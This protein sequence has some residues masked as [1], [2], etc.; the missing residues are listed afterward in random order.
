MLR[1]K[2][3]WDFY[4]CVKFFCEVLCGFMCEFLC[5]VSVWVFVRYCVS[6]CVG[7][8]VGFC[9]SFCVGFC[10]NF[11]EEFYKSVRF[12]RSTKSLMMFGGEIYTYKLVSFLATLKY[13][14]NE[15]HDCKYP[16]HKYILLNLHCEYLLDIQYTVPKL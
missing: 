14:E 6:F 3:K 12:M 8:C 5:G 4:W 16:M 7:F 1:Y 15:K 10:E 13:N 2:F 11:C 9:V